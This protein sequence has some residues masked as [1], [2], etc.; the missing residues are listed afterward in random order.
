MTV[1][2]IGTILYVVGMF[3]YV[4]FLWRRGGLKRFE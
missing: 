1:R 4:R 2:I 3:F